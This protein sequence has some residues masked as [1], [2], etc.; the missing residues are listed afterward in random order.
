MKL[1]VLFMLTATLVLLHLLSASLQAQE[2]LLFRVNVPFEFVA[3][4]VHFSAGE[5]LAFHAT[6]TMI[7]L[8]RTDGQASTWI[9]VKPSPVASGVTTNQIVFNR[10]GDSYFL[11][12]VRTGHD[13]QIHECFRCRSEK[14]LAAQYRPS[15][16]KTVA[17]NVMPAK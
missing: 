17:L 4:G 14:T 7:Q 6:P 11:S 5:Y 13:Q 3:G 9:P 12:Q 10:Y 1:R 8:V 2:Q 15:D 16:V